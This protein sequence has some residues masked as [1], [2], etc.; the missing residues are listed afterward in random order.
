M[1]D[2]ING[3]ELAASLQRERPARRALFVVADAGEAD[4]ASRCPR[5]RTG[6]CTAAPRRE[7]ARQGRPRPV[8]R[9]RGRG[10]PARRL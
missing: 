6:C 7:P 9:R 3:G 10:P 8:G 5:R 4:P 2:D 1:L